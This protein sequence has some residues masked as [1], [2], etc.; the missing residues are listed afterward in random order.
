M[1]FGQTIDLDTFLHTHGI[2]PREEGRLAMR[3]MASLNPAT[4]AANVRNQYLLAG[5]GE[6]KY[7][8]PLQALGIAV[9]VALIAVLLSRL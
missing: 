8:M 1:H 7:R 9:V 2:D 5:L 3:E 4:R 6:S